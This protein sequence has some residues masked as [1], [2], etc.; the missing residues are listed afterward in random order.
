ME[1][2]LL[3]VIHVTAIMYNGHSTVF[4]LLWN[5]HSESFGKTY[6]EI[7][8]TEQNDTTS[9]W[10]MTITPM[11]KSSLIHADSDNWEA[12]LILYFHYTTFK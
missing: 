5:V 1:A 2:K 3:P 7:Y 12:R 9:A 11:H 8:T 6:L 10:E 4:C